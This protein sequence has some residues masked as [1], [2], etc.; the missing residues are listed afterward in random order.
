MP[1]KPKKPE[2]ERR[3]HERYSAKSGT[4]RIDEKAGEIIDISMGGLSFSYVDRGDWSD[5]SFDQ[6]MLFGDND[7]CLEDLPLKIIS[8]CAINSGLSIIRRCGVKFEGLTAK[9]LSQLEYFI[10]ANSYGPDSNDDDN[11]KA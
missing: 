8:D 6:G 7:L 5:T 11:F 10:W 1:K 2:Q 9:Q 4:I 3:Q